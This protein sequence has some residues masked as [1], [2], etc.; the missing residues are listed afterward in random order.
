MSAVDNFQGKRGFQKRE[1]L[2][3]KVFGAWTVFRYIGRG[4]YL[5]VCHCKKERAILSKSLKGGDSRSCGAAECKRAG[6]KPPPPP[7]KFTEVKYE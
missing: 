4:T 1:E 5:C 7:K 3:G 6:A 2:E